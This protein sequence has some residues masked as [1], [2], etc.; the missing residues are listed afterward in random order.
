MGE[1]LFDDVDLNKLV[2][3]SEQQSEAEQ[4]RLSQQYA[5]E[6]EPKKAREDYVAAQKLGL[7]VA[8]VEFSPIAPPPALSW[9]D[10]QRTSPVL[11]KSLADPAVAA[12]LYPDIEKMKKS[13]GLFQG[14]DDTLW[15][16]IER[17]KA[18][19]RTQELGK[20]WSKKVLRHRDPRRPRP[21]QGS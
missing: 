6:R 1:G 17:G 10:L 7:P 16:T 18:G 11:A 14:W 5:E 19:W 12:A 13:E 9:D 20:L 2:P 4:L 21:N 15:N 8:A 3:S